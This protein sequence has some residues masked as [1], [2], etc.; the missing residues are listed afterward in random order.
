M[1]FPLTSFNLVTGTDWNRLSASVNVTGSCVT[2]RK[3]NE[4]LRIVRGGLRSGAKSEKLEE[5]V[6]ELY[7][8]PAEQQTYPNTAALWTLSHETK[9]SSFQN[10]AKKR[11]EKHCS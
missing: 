2:S 8:S 3:S 6:N 4:S 7:Q 9:I 10:D 11:E 5:M 1:S